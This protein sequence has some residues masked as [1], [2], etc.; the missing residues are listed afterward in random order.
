ML[1]SHS[2]YIWHFFL[3]DQ[4]LPSNNKSDED[5]LL[6]GQFG[7]GGLNITKVKKVQ[8][9]LCL[10]VVSTDWIIDDAK[11]HYLMI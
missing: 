9:V 8:Q 2:Q 5:L 7:G 1:S 3:Q 11:P 10:F 6:D 4:L